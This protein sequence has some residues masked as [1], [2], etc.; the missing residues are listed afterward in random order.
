MA[1]SSRRSFTW[2]LV[3]SFGLALAI[4]ATIAVMAY[5]STGE[6]VEATERAVRTQAFLNAID[7]A[8]TD[9]IDAETGARGYVLV[10]DSRFLEPYEAALRKFEP[11]LRSLRE[12][13][14]GDPVAAGRLD[15]IEALAALKL[16]FLAQTIEL[17]RGGD[18]PAATAQI[19]TGRGKAIMDDIRR[20]AAEMRDAEQAAL[21]ERDQAVRLGAQR[22]TTVI[23]GGSTLAALLIALS[24]WVAYREA[25]ARRKVNQALVRAH[26]GLEARVRER[27]AELAE[28]NNQLG[29]ALDEVQRTQDAML[30][31][32]RLRAVGELASGIAHDFNNSLATIVGYTELLLSDPDGL[33]NR[34]AV[35]DNLHLI[36]S[37]AEDAANVVGRLREFYRP[38]EAGEDVRPVQVNDVIARA[39]SL[40]QP[41]W[42]DQAQ[43][44]GRTIRVEADLHDVPPVAGREAELREALTNLILNA[45]D[46]MPEGGTLTLRSRPEGE[47]VAV[48][49]SDSGVGMPPEVRARIFEPF[50]TTKGERGTGLG[51]AMVHGIVQRHG[52]ELDVSS[53]P[54]AGTTFT[55]RLPVARETAEEAPV[56]APTGTTRSLHVLVAEDELSL[57]RILTS[58]LRA[59]DHA[60][61][62]AANGR[63]ALER[64]GGGQF[65]LVIT[66]RAMPDMG[67]DQLAAALDRLAPDVPVIMLTGLGELMNEVKECPTGVDLV[68]AKPITLARLRAAVRAAVAGHDG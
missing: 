32:E 53:A 8:V 61:E 4:L 51:L 26:E 55:I 59:D 11:D 68:V 64:F 1:R 34:A 17:R 38:R 30:R 5:R 2:L 22:A 52:G 45:V 21:L 60:V 28:A 67:G 43:A 65:D 18:A 10:G 54:G 48:D 7:R 19:A 40:T 44:G 12:M 15:A 41:R 50:F 46:A 66:D 37:A 3:A 16:A 24:T 35:R 58:F 31:Q 27:T 42:R 6:L 49:V 47:R 33:E 57:R 63:E 39:I 20:L 23:L 14:A 29:Q 9:L 13:A 25:I 56:A 62:V 36:H